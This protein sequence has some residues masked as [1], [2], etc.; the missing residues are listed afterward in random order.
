MYECTKI[1][2]SLHIFKAYDLKQNAK[3]HKL[4]HS[5]QIGRRPQSAELQT[6]VYYRHISFS[7]SFSDTNAVFCDSKTEM[8]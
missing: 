6:G 8:Y 7:S 1:N 4:V 2:E 3:I 5:R